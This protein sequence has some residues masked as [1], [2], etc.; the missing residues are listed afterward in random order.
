MGKHLLL[1]F[2]YTVVAKGQKTTIDTPGSKGMCE[3][4]FFSNSL[5][6]HHGVCTAFFVLQVQFSSFKLGF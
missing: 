2:Y 4:C 5:P 6:C 1:D 3:R